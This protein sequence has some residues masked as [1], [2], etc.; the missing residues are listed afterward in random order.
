MTSKEIIYR[1]I[2]YALIEIRMDARSMQGKKIFHL[3]DLL[4]NIP[5]ALEKASVAVS[6]DGILNQIKEDAKDK[7]MERWVE[8]VISNQNR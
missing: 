2:Y 6:Y 4:H 7:G 1:L 3:A 8:N 5:L